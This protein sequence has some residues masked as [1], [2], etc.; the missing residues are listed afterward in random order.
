[1]L[2][3]Y[4]EEEDKENNG[5]NII[6]AYIQG[7]KLVERDNID[8]ETELSDEEYYID[9]SYESIEDIVNPKKNHVY[10]ITSSNSINILKNQLFSTAEQNMRG[11]VL[12]ENKQISTINNET[13]LIEGYFLQNLNHCIYYRGGWYL[14][15]LQDKMVMGIPV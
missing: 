5:T 9:D 10:R 8:S 3:F 1:M 4:N 6:G 7:I 15:S 11:V 13:A 12:E 2:E 14:F